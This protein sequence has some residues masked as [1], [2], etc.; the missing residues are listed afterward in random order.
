MGLQSL[1]LHSFILSLKVHIRAQHFSPHKNVRQEAILDTILASC[2]SK[3]QFRSLTKHTVA[4]TGHTLS[5]T[6]QMYVKSQAARCLTI[7]QGI[8]QFCQ[9]VKSCLD[10]LI[11]V[12]SQH[13]W[14]MSCL[15]TPW[16]ACRSQYSV[17]GDE[18]SES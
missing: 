10:I 1:P 16:M 4:P 17:H 18:V 2:I 11:S 13:L 12:P 15:H 7:A 6:Q 3:G 14:C 9:Q 8:V 5:E